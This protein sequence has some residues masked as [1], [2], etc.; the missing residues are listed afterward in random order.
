MSEFESLKRCYHCGAVLQ[1]EDQEKEGYLSPDISSLC[2][3]KEVL[4][5]DSCYKKQ[6]Y[7]R[8]PMKN[9]A[10]NDF[11]MMLKDAK[12][13]DALI[14]HVIDLTSFECSFDINAIDFMKGLNC[15]II[16]NKRD[17]IPQN[18]ADEDLKEYVLNVYKEYGVDIK[19]GDIYLASLLSPS[20]DISDIRKEVE[21]RRKGHDVYIIGD[22][23]SGKSMFLNAFLKDYRN[24]SNNPVGVSR[25]FGTDLDVLKIP[26]DST[27]YIYDTPG[28]LLSNSFA[29][30]KDDQT[31]SNYL[32]SD[33]TY[34]SKK[35]SI[36]EGGSIF[37]STLARL[38]YLQGDKRIN[39]SLH[40]PPKIQTKPI[41]PKKN[42]NELFLK[43]H[44]KKALKPHASFITSM[45]DYDIFDISIKGDGDDYKQITISGL[46]WMS[47]KAE[48][49]MKFRIYV[50]KGIGIYIGK[51]KGHSKNVNTK[52]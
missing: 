44:E 49:S 43:Y 29:R 9:K 41:T 14:V 19:K 10:S 47:F 6:R 15:I 12:A 24:P 13:S 27:S 16:G 28:N 21:N 17:L 31:I 4:L 23:S 35:I 33:K 26:L 8:A 5:C 42:M 46:G 32:F 3:D 18:Y 1:S 7:N 39:L 40:F 34:I 51:A 50:P 38:D 48:N 52:K 37:I 22:L 11:L 2:G 30:Y 45:S 25:Y 20:F 36:Y